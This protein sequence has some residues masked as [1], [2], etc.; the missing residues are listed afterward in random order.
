MLLD[1]KESI[2]KFC[3]FVSSL[4][5]PN[6]KNKSFLDLGSQNINMLSFASFSGAYPIVWVS[7]SSSQFDR[8]DSSLLDVDVYPYDFQYLENKKFDVI[9]LNSQLLS[10]DNFDEVI[11][12]VMQYLNQDG[13][14]VTDIFLSDRLLSQTNSNIFTRRFISKK[15]DKYAWKIFG[16][17]LNESD[18]VTH[19]VLHIKNRKPYVFLMMEK[20]GSG[21]STLSRFFFKANNVP[22]LSGDGLYIKIANG[23]IN[24]PERLFECVKDDFRRY[25]IDKTIHKVFK[26]NLHVDFFSVLLR[27]S[28]GGDIAIDTYVPNFYWKT[29]VE[30]MRSKGYFPVVM[31]W[32]G[33]ND[34]ISG[35]ETNALV[36]SYEKYLLSY[37]FEKQI[38][39]EKIKKNKDLKNFRWHIDTPINGDVLNDVNVKVSGWLCFNKV[40]QPKAMVFLRTQSEVLEFSLDRTRNDVRQ[41]LQ[42]VFKQL[43][44]SPDCTPLGFSFSIDKSILDNSVLGVICENKST[45]LIKFELKKSSEKKWFTFSH[46]GS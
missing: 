20:P 26:K 9:Y 44:G 28:R 18:D 15:C 29:V 38:R 39:I 36:E 35:K 27:K 14:L 17:S 25:A 30:F 7:D 31:G 23:D 34:L 37:P 3:R 5:F 16:K 41:K 1:N 40:S 4:R 43:Q 2:Y 19:R 24:V 22:V 6:L 42:S 46:K 12:K 21:K 32:E 45:D 10:I 33:H 13:K 8:N 11:A